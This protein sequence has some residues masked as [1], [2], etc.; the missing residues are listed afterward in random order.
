MVTRV[1][2]L[3]LESKGRLDKSKQAFN[4]MVRDTMKLLFTIAAKSNPNATAAYQFV[5]ENGGATISDLRNRPWGTVGSQE[6]IYYL[7]RGRTVRVPA[8][9][10]L[11]FCEVGIE[12]FYF[13]DD[14]EGGCGWYLFS[15]DKKFQNGDDEDGTEK[16]NGNLH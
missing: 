2:D 15:E 4:F 14:G 9:P 6:E 7:S 1:L 8:A 16:E 10:Y 3:L 12:A 11:H 5:S 13:D